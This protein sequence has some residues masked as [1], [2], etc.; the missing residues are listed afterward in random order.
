M[1]LNVKHGGFIRYNAVIASTETV[2]FK[3]GRVLTLDSSAEAIVN[4]G[5]TTNVVG[6][7]VQDRIPSTQYSP[8]ASEL[9]STPTGD[10]TALLLDESVVTDDQISGNCQ[11]AVGGAV[12]TTSDGLLTTANTNNR[13]IGKALAVNDPGK[14]LEFLFTVQY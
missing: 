13:V 8:T 1:S 6:L 14:T 10:R 2:V 9:A 12:Y 4:D 11:W 3:A 5:G 7:A